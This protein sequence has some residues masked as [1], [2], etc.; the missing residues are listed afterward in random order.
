VAPGIQTSRSR[1]T[2]DAL[3]ADAAA[4]SFRAYVGYAGWGPHQLDAELARGA[5]VVAPAEVESVFPEEPD[6]LWRRLL[7][8]FQPIRVELRRLLDVS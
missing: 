1:I 4:P 2:L 5:W 6:S 3:L 7:R 8:R